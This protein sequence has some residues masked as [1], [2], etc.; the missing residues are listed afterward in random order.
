M[1]GRLEHHGHHTGLDGDVEYEVYVVASDGTTNSPASTTVTATP[2]APSALAGVG[3]VLQTSAADLGWFDVTY[4]NGTFVAVAG[5]GV[6]SNRVM[7]STDGIS[8]ISRESANDNLFWYGVTFGNGLFVAVAQSGT[9]NRVMTSPDGITWTSRAS[10]NDNLNWQDV[11][12][13][14]PGGSPLFAAVGSA[15]AGTQRIMTSPDGITWTARETGSVFTGGQDIAYGNGRFVTV[16]GTGTGTRAMTSTDGITWT[17]QNTPADVGWQSVAYGTPGGNPLFVAVATSGSP[18]RV[19]TS[20]DGE[21]WTLRS[22]GDDFLASWKT[23]SNVTYGAGKFVAVA[24]NGNSSGNRVMTSTDG[25]TWT[26]EVT[27]ADNAWTSVVYG[28]GRFVAVGASGT[29]DRVMISPEPLP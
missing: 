7:T 29:G 18:E 4:G 15:G 6:G 24:Q 14:T 2:S 27:P 17:L 25:I 1:A 5:S 13:G 22:S 11:T 12:Y 26:R 10:A 3:W 21:T 20:P 16:G 23:W 8:W 19:M 28:N 9:G